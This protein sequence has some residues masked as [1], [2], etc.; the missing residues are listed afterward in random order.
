MG[1][2]RSLA[3][4]YV[5]AGAPGVGKTTLL[6]ELVRLGTGI[7]AIDMDELLE[8][9]ALI[10]VPIAD[11]SAAPSWPAYNRM[12][13]RIVDIVR[14]AGHP[15]ILLCPTPA[16]EDLMAGDGWDGPVRWAL[17]D[18]DDQR[19]LD[20]LRARDWPEEWIEDAMADAAQT[21]GLIPTVIHTDSENAREIAGRI[22]AW[23]ESFGDR[24][25][26]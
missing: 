17:L 14:R 20:R 26:P 22:L 5:V 23:T 7:V 12:W 3:P 13:G 6:P 19:R 9:G 18:C 21:R 10:G 8:D 25:S 24:S 11:P 1:G 4:L 16:P 15:V 2:E